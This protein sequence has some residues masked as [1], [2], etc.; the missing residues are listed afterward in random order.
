MRS[1]R[2]CL[3]PI[4]L[5][6][7]CPSRVAPAPERF[8]NIRLRL[9]LLF[10]AVWLPAAAGFGLLARSI[11]LHETSST[12]EQVQQY[13]RGLN[14]LIERELDKRAVMART[15]GASASLKR[16]ELQ[17]FYDEASA[18]AH[19]TD[20]WIILVTPTVEVMNTRVAWQADMA[21]PRPAGAPMATGEPGV[22]FTAK[23]PVTHRPVIALFGPE[24]GVTPPAYDIGVAFD[25]SII[26]TVV[27]RSPMPDA[28]VSVIDNRQ[29][30]MAR[31]RDPAVWLGRT[32]GDEIRRRAAAGMEGFLESRTLDG[33]ASLTYL[34]GPNR[35]HWNVIVATPKE[36]VGATARRLTLQAVGAAS[37]LL[38]IGLCLVLYSSNR[39]GRLID[40]LQAA[41]MTLREDRIPPPMA[42]GV[43]EI[44]GV[45]T[46]LH[47]AGIRSHEAT[48]TLEDRVARAV[49]DA[50][51]AQAKL[52][53]GQK[54]EAI[55]RLTG[56]LAHDF[57]N[58]LQTI[59]TGLQVIEMSRDGPPPARVV[60]AAVR[61][62]NRAA[63][64]VKQMLAFSRA[65]PQKLAAVD[66]SDFLLGARELI[67]KAIGQGIE[68]VADV[69]PGLPPLHV[70]PTQ[71]ELALLNLIFNARDAMPQGG[72]ITVGARSNG[73]HDVVVEVADT[74]AGMDEPTRVRAMEPYFTTKAI[75][76]GS[77]LGLAQ[78]RAF[79]LQSGGDVRLHSEP[80]VGTR[81]EM[82]LPSIDAAPEKAAVGPNAAPGRSLRVLMVEDD[83]LVA[84]VVVPALTA[85]GHSITLCATA[86]SAAELL[87]SGALFDV[88]FTDVMMP[89]KMNGM[90]LRAW[91][92][93]HRPELP[94]VVATGYSAQSSSDAEILSK[95]Y[96][97]GELSAALSRAA[98][99]TRGA[100]PS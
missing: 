74:G 43:P 73:S 65:R 17:T 85:T 68:L 21:L 26:Q 16:R 7:P 83:P 36:F 15:L 82:L 79:S 29:L 88:V 87:G 30:I 20:S 34:T 52:L 37:G 10:L 99:A 23:R 56:G 53:D 50:Q 47:E 13:A 42:S 75:G 71:L 62:T 28:L 89:G 48:R 54:H 22:F 69:E 2:E 27:E 91:C 59:R 66:F 94:V 4:E 39:I 77:G 32:A 80:G 67:Q 1:A 35:Y 3:A 76:A 51:D 72:R 19:E 44:D 14:A 18:A 93:R 78:V 6:H 61:A 8:L 25:P 45:S 98:A 31:T 64:L 60:E 95:P 100:D 24:L 84:S 5:F 90:E 40:A 46:V 97:L 96:E 11:Y 92:A 49:Q 63:E 38:L 81:V 33:V 57:N 86:D 12:Q 70:D 41:A 58:L 55:G 9:L